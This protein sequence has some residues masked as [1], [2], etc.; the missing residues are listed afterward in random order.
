MPLQS[1][2]NN[3]FPLPPPPPKKCIY[4]YFTHT[5]PNECD[6]CIIKLFRDDGPEDMYEAPPEDMIQGGGPSGP[7]LPPRDGISPGRKISGPIAAPSLRPPIGVPP[8]R[9]PRTDVKDESPTISPNSDL[10]PPQVGSKDRS[11]SPSRPSVPKRNYVDIVPQPRP[12]MPPPT[13]RPP[14]PPVSQQFRI[15]HEVLGSIPGGFP[16]LFFL[17]LLAY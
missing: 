1:W 3:I 16:G 7:T 11:S 13:T 10:R 12:P 6:A 2:T 8:R 15:V 9:P 4:A 14:I 5:Y 17:F